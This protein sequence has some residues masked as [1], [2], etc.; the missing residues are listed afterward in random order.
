MSVRRDTNPGVLGVKESGCEVDQSH[1]PELRLRMR[2]AI[3]LLLHCAFIAW[4]EL[5][6]PIFTKCD[7]L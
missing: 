4:A 6:L 7:S 5:A 2:G 3:P 1:H